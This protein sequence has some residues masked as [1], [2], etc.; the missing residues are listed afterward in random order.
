MR[1]RQV[2]AVA[3]V[4]VL[5]VAGLVVARML[6]ARDARRNSE[7][8]AQVAAAQV[9]GRVVQATTLTESV[10]QFMLDASGAGVTNDDFANN[11]L[12]WLGP[13][14]IQAAAWVE[15]VPDSARVAYEQR[16]G[17]PIVSL[18]RHDFVPEGVRATY[19]P[20][21]LV[22]GFEP[23]SVPGTDLSREPRLAAALSR[24]T[25]SDGVAASAL[26]S[27]TPGTPGLFFVAPA[28]NLI[29]R[30][31]QQGYVVV[32][33][34]APTLQAATDEPGVEIAVGGNSTGGGESGKTTSTTF[35][36]A[37][38]VFSVSVPRE[39]VRGAWA[40]LPWIILGAGLGLAALAAALN[41]HSTRRA[42]AQA[43]LD[44]VFKLS[45]DVIAVADFNGYFTRINP[46]AERILGYSEEE[47]LARPYTDFVHPDDRGRTDAET[48][49]MAHG[50][51]VYAFENRYVRKDGAERVLEWTSTPVLKDGL[52]YAVGRD[53]TDR[54]NAEREVQ[55]LAEEQAA[56]RRVATLVARDAPHTE[57]FTAIAEEVGDLLGAEQARMFVFER[58]HMARLIASAG[59][60][61][62]AFAIGSRWEL[63]GE[64]AIT[65]VFD[66]RAA[67][68]LDDIREASGEVGE[69]ARSMG[70]R[71][72]VAT[73]ITV[74]DRLWGAI[75]LATTGD[76]LLPPE[77]EVRGA[78]FTALM[79]TA[80]A[81]TESQA[82]ANRLAD[83]RAALRRVATL[84]AE[85][86][87]PA[88]I[89]D[90]VT[91]EMERVLDADQVWL[92]R[93]GPDDEV[94][95]LARRGLDKARTPLGVQLDGAGQSATAI[96]RRTGKP[97]R[98]VG[99]EE[100]ESHGA[101]RARDT[102][103]RSSVAAPIV[104]DGRLWGVI[105]ASWKGD[106]SPPA[107]TEDRM[108][109]F[110][111]LLGTAVANADSRDQLMTSRAR[112]LT[113]ADEARRHVVR[114][115]HDG[116]QQRLVHTIVKLKLARNALNDGND[117]A[118]RL[119]ADA[120]D[121]A[122]QGVSE[123]RE[124]AHGILPAALTHYG[125]RAGVDALVAR[126]TLP[127]DV[128]IPPD[129]WP[130]EIES[131]AYF[132]IAEALT[133]V[134]KHADSSRADVRARVQ[135]GALHIEVSDDG[136]GGADPT[137]H[138]LVGLA[139]RVAALGGQ[140]TIDSA[141]NDGTALTATLPF[142]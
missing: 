46:A 70:L 39:S 62:G 30:Q 100:A 23:M 7:R 66:T 79:A 29:G 3:L 90:A 115:L 113:A 120:I 138:G 89:F 63:G 26:T 88:S 133:N 82:R 119:V 118:E 73:P 99:Y 1:L 2:A 67:A 64:N 52:A 42:R 86:G 68:R 108:V 123:L 32:F 124:L 51:Q 58:D 110:A 80:I 18:G 111:Q 5:A 140:L 106:E 72:V 102:G 109:R 121:Q 95:L 129:R 65:R 6:A 49:A 45:G 78:Q 12:R 98:M 35:R 107:D 31:L 55:R 27:P 10:R 40:A 81:N 83:E 77:T 92:N 56:L 36:A 9:R 122:E 44:R 76:K 15:P 85:G 105:T 97:A 54:R 24:A 20:A 61:G 91:G 17:H 114:D 22:S 117:D 101:E 93:F 130:A 131:S 127:V 71:S 60:G 11:A 13:A 57:V 132:I 41:R 28:P 112:L 87:S 43:E 128:D 137:G 84:V 16:T 126:L 69:A 74:D 75:V 19:L 50:K 139:D 25:R 135:D 33:V 136:I 38:E 103:P 94:V 14:D 47:L 59:Q 125:L 134:V 96:V 141:R 37:G 142:S 8:N 104:V 48:A 116:A 21:T 34:S 53:I 4:L